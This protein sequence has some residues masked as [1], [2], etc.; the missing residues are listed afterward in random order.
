MKYYIYKICC[1]DLP[2]FVYVG[3]TGAFANRKYEHKSRC[4][5]ENDKKYNLKLYKTIRANGGW[6]KWQ[7]ICIAQVECETKTQAVII[8]ERY[9]LELNGNMNNR[10]CYIT[11]EQRKEYDKEYRKKYYE[12]TKK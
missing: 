10:R 1:E 2:D 11:E 8:E 9:R 5:N 12:R 7:M 6:D 4:N 3:S